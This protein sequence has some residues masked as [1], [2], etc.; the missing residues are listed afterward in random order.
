MGLVLGAGGAAGAAFHAGVLAAL[1]EVTGW[2]PRR[3]A[4]VVG[5]SAGSIT[6]SALRAGLSAADHLARAEGRPL[7]A[8][9]HRLV[10][11]VARPAMSPLRPARRSAPPA[12]LAATLARA[13]TRPFAARP[14]AVL[15]GLLPEGAVST[16]GIADAVRALHARQWPADPLWVCAVRQADGRRIVFGRDGNEPLVE[17]A[18]AASCAIPGFFRPVA[19]GGQ[20]HIDGGVHSPTNADVL[21]DFG[22][23][24]LVV[25]S[26]PMSRWGRRPRLAADRPMRAWARGHSMRR[27]AACVESASRCWLSN[28]MTRC[29]RRWASTPWTPPGPGPSPPGPVHRP[30]NGWVG[31]TWPS[32]WLPSAERPNQSVSWS[33]SSRLRIFPAALRGSWPVGEV[34]HGWAP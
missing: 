34:H 33:R 9:G 1:E 30:S 20:L 18:V 13:M 29:S 22:P 2:D 19:V 32:G 16:D 31:P 12:Q 7:S 21:R 26:S 11:Q 4:V 14:L 5:T 25:I 10:G 24:D 15:A 23:L 17:E 8:A 6:G 27:S 28:P 3:A